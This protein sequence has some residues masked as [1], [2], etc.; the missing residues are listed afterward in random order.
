MIRNNPILKNLLEIARNIWG[1]PSFFSA[2][3]KYKKMA[4]QNG[5]FK[6]KFPNLYPCLSDKL[7]NTPFDRHYILHTA[8]ASRKI[9]EINPKKHT[10]ISST[11]NFCTTL[12][13][14]VP[15]EFYD[16]RPLQ[17]KL[18]NLNTGKA[19]LT[20]LPFRDGSIESL[21]CM[22]TVEHIGLG[23]YGDTID[24]NGDIKAMN[25]LTRVLAQGG[26]LLFVIPVGKPKLMFNAHRIY[27]YR[28]ILEHF[29]DLKLVEFTLIP[30]NHT[31]GDLITNASEASANNENYG[32]GCF[33]FQKNY[34]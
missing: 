3:V 7:A 2:Y 15:T 13:A 4:A 20:N 30:E 1:L 25:E 17:I 31:R 19:D 5:R 29:K 6:I 28:Q 23:R 32:C 24:P 9:A 33:H 8:W 27:S 14:F 18:S 12:S 16:Y 10:D 21:S 26:H 22:H 11:I 34:K